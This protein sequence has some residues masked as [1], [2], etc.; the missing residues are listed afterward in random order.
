MKGICS[1]C[2]C[3]H[4]DPC[5]EGCGWANLKQTLCT[6]CALLDADQR[7]AKRDEAIEM[8]RMELLRVQGEEA[9]LAER[10]V[11]LLCTESKSPA[12]ASDKKKRGGTQ[13]RSPQ[14]R[15]RYPRKA[16]VS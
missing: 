2:G 13:K 11:A 4:D 6:A 15:P 7:E 14:Q 10:L 3:T 9:F 16:G 8:L 1:V 12:A 5:D